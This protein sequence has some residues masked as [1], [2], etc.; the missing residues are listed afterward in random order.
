VPT[1]EWEWF[2]MD[3]LSVL[4]F[5][6]T[7]RC[8]LSCVHCGR[9]ESIAALKELPASFFEGVVDDALELGLEQ[10]NITGGEIF[11]RSDA[12]TLINAIAKKGVFVSIE[13]NGVLLTPTIID[14]LAK[15]GDALRISFSMD[16][17]DAETH[18][19][20]RGAG[21]F[22]A[23]MDT[24]HYV[25]SR[26]ISARI[27]TVLHKGNKH[28]IIP[29]ARY[30]NGIGLGFRLLPNIIEY[31]KG[32][33][34]CNVYGVSYDETHRILDE[35]YDFL[36]QSN[37][38][39]NS[40]EM[41]IALL[42]LDIDDSGF[43]PWGSNMLG[44]GPQGIASLCHVANNESGF[45]FGDLTKTSVKEIW[46]DNAVLAAFRNLDADKLK[47]VCGNCLARSLCRG[48]CRLHAVSKYGDFYAPDPQCQAFYN[49]GVFPDHAIEDEG[50]DCTYPGR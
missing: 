20:I 39:R 24:I 13:T 35:Y 12:I 6:M 45:I 43:C 3:K 42:P 41:N 1:K 28:Q 8:N 34:A 5:N 27:I 33:Y 10:V 18:D 31:G 14:E 46:E 2:D 44:V 25:S 32:V 48:A 50:I 23:T 36:R 21:A 29:M 38:D 30:F 7:N 37:S 15:L 26:G 47:G 40:I 22:T 11:I 9:D 17:F 49:L 19:S 16:G 4:A